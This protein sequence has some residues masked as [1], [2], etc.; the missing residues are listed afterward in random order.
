MKAPEQV[1]TIM[2]RRVVFAAPVALSVVLWTPDLALPFLLA[3]LLGWEAL[4][5]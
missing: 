5:W 1:T 3:L 4:P 2:V